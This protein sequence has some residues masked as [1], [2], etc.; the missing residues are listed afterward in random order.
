M[1][2]LFEHET[3]QDLDDRPCSYS[4]RVSDS[5]VRALDNYR[6]QLRVD[7]MSKALRLLL[8]DLATFNATNTGPGEMHPRKKERSTER[9]RGRSFNLTAANLRALEEF[10]GHI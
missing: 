4:F 1:P 3:L 5:A 2:P 10:G 9:L 8:E 6:R 7:S